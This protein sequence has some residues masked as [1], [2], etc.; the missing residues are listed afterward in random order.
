MVNI[1]NKIE[2]Q[3]ESL[4]AYF[5]SLEE[6]FDLF[7]TV[8]KGTFVTGS[9]RHIFKALAQLIDEDKIIKEN[10]LFID[11]GS[12]DGRICAIASILG[13]QSYGIE[14][15]ETIVDSSLENIRNLQEKGVLS[16][17]E[18]TYPKIVRGDI[19][20][21]SSYD[22]LGIPFT[23][24]HVIFNFVTYH[25]DLT[26]K[27]KEKSPSGTI[28]ILHSPCPITFLPDGFDKIKE[29]PLSGIYQVLYVYR[30]I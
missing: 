1:S 25:E 7:Y 30:K 8:D 20:E 19:F 12:G 10:D 29:I 11:A 27:I 5:A 16:E 23:D 24:Y 15:N 2:Q 28:F 26:M 9:I 6:R 17:R 22:K 21:D 4:N 14:Y 18:G 13:L 3:I